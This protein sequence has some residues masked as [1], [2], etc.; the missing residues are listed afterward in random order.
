MKWGKMQHRMKWDEM[1]HRMIE[2]RWNT[3]WSEVDAT[4]GEVGWDATQDE[5][6]MKWGRQRY[7]GGGWKVP[8]VP[9]PFCMSK[10][11]LTVHF[12]GQFPILCVKNF[13]CMPLLHL[14]ANIL[15]L[16]VAN[17]SFVCQY[18]ICMSKPRMLL[19]HLYVNTLFICHC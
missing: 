19:P 15:Y 18:F 16:Y 10:A 2:V 7:G 4:Q 5:Y 6:R 11:H 1:Q 8:K 14:Y 9:F 12:N 17:T 3:G 13:I